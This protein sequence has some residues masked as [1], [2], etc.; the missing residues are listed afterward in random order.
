MIF[1][2]T[3]MRFLKM[4][5]KTQL[6][7]KQCQASM[8]AARF[9]CVAN[10]RKT[11]LTCCKWP[12]VQQTVKHCQMAKQPAAA[13]HAANGETHCKHMTN[14]NHKT[15]KCKKSYKIKILHSQ[16]LKKHATNKTN[17][18]EIAVNTNNNCK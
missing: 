1:K 5:G 8:V 17:S 10:K 3:P 12:K 9:K 15:H 13:K 16:K 18:K 7:L 14:S 4:C 2:C 6:S 11:N